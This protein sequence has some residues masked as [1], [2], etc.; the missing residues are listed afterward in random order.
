M[1][2]PVHLVQYLMSFNISRSLSLLC[3]C[4]ALCLFRIQRRL[5]FVVSDCRVHWTKTHTNT[6]HTFFVKFADERVI[7]CCS[8]YI[9]YSL[10]PNA[11]LRWHIQCQ[12]VVLEIGKV[13]NN[14]RRVKWNFMRLRCKTYFIN[15]QKKTQCTA[16][17]DR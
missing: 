2:A 3:L 17:R 5:P 11:I 8:F 6:I 14:K 7:F 13:V 15:H 10:R 16:Q 9:T 12:S 4:F 1:V